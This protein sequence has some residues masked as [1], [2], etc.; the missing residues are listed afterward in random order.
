[1]VSKGKMADGGMMA[2]GGE[3]KKYKL[4]FS[5]QSEASADIY[6]V[7]KENDNYVFLSKNRM[8]HILKV[9]KKS[10]MVKGIK[11][12]KDGYQWD[13]PRAIKLIEIKN[14][15]EGGVMMAK[16]GKIAKRWDN[17]MDFREKLTSDLDL[18]KNYRLYYKW[19]SLPQNIKEQI[20]NYENSN[21]K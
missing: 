21:K 11:D 4:V 16:G 12:G 13:V 14:H 20:E 5:N 1:M 15:E 7:E 10:L 3:F 18:Y 17:D 2:K 19:K 8:P 9:N 6:N